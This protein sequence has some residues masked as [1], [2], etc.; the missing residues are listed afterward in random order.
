[1]API[2]H[3]GYAAT[4]ASLVILIAG[5]AVA[6]STLLY[7]K[8]EASIKALKEYS[9]SNVVEVD[10]KTVCDYSYIV[11][12]CPV[13]PI[14]VSLFTGNISRYNT[15]EA[16]IRLRD[17][18]IQAVKMEEKARHMQQRGTRER[19]PIYLPSLSIYCGNASSA[20]ERIVLVREASGNMLLA[21]SLILAGDAGLVASWLLYRAGSRRA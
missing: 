3:I 11:V 4:L 6:S 13:K 20:P 15:T 18:C 16:K 17:N 14:V 5:I 21:L 12:K 19:G 1:M 7:G 9:G 2:R 10:S 8:V